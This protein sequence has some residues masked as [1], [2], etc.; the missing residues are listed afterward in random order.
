M[1]YT[2]DQVQAA[3]AQ[4]DAATALT[5]KADGDVR[6]AAIAAQ[7]GATETDAALAAAQAALGIVTPMLAAFA[8][9]LG[10][11]V[12]PPPPPPPTSGWQFLTWDKIAAATPAGVKQNLMPRTTVVP[13]PSNPNGDLHLTQTGQTVTNV[14]VAGSIIS[15]APGCV[16]NNCTGKNAWSQSSGGGPNGVGLSV[17]DGKYTGSPTDAGIQYGSYYAERVELTKS[18]DGVKAFSAS[19]LKSCWIHG[20]LAGGGYD[21]AP[22]TGGSGNSAGNYTHNDGLQSSGGAGIYLLDSRIEDTGYNSGAFFDPDQGPIDGYEVGRSYLQGGNF[23]LFICHATKADGTPNPNHVNG[24]Y[25]HDNE[26]GFPAITAP[27][28]AGPVNIEQHAQWPQVG[29]VRYENN[30]LEDGTPAT[31]QYIAS[32]PA[33]KRYRKHVWSAA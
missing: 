10:I 23:S 27:A 14:D 7:L 6:A 19:T 13:T 8:T 4:L 25:V 31:A 20:L 21:P 29:V 12:P 5:S 28:F 32:T 2:A 26:F 33:A 24:G 30:R 9:T 18:F 16:A 15:Q 3:A 1:T 11:P 22:G 17:Y